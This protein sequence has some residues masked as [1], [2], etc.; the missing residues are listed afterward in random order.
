MWLQ[1]HQQQ[2]SEGLEVVRYRQSALI[3]SLAAVL[4]L[5]EIYCLDPSSVLEVVALGRQVEWQEQR[6][7]DQR[8]RT[9]SIRR[10]RQTIRQKKGQRTLR[11]MQMRRDRALAEAIAL[12]WQQEATGW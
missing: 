8:A 1:Q 4:R 5:L 11:R 7:I 2:D 3:S 9:L 10:V 12:I 6:P